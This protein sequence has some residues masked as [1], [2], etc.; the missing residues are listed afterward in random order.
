MRKAGA[1][2][3]GCSGALSETELGRQCVVALFDLG[4]QRVFACG[5]EGV[6]LADGHHAYRGYALRMVAVGKAVGG[7]DK[8]EQGRGEGG[9]GSGV[10]REEATL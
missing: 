4:K 2:G 5:D 6:K 3:G 7:V 10:R 1:I 9:E 8:V